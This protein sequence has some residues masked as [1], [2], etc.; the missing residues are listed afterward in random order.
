MAG[1]ALSRL[2]VRF[3]GQ[4]QNCC[5][6]ELCSSGYVSRAR[7]STFAAR[8]ALGAAG[9]ALSQLEVRF[10]WQAQHFRISSTLRVAGEAHSAGSKIA[11]IVQ[12]LYAKRSFA[13][14]ARK[15]RFAGPA[16]KSQ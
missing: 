6:A 12:K 2:E 8:I 10:A 1:A 14:L 11:K 4:A 5:G 15:S 9:V 3:A 16:R 13:A 7:H